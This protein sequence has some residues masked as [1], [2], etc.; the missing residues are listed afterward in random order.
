[1]DRATAAV[2]DRGDRLLDRPRARIVRG[3]CDADRA[4]AALAAGWRRPGHAA[5]LRRVVEIGQAELDVVMMDAPWR[6]LRERIDVGGGRTCREHPVVAGLELAAGG[7][8]VEVDEDAGLDGY[9][10]AG[11]RDRNQAA[12]SRVEV[13]IESTVGFQ[14]LALLIPALE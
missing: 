4:R 8:K 2:D 13:D 1:A 11:C 7:N 10:G 5:V 6:R 9:L 12:G 3:R 14:H